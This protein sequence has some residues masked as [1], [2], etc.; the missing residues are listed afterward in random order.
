MRISR[1][2]DW[3]PEALLIVLIMVMPL[4]ALE[5]LAVRIVG[6]PPIN[7]QS[8]AAGADALGGPFAMRALAV[9]GALILLPAMRRF[10]N[11]PNAVI[12]SRRVTR[13]EQ[14]V[15]FAVALVFGLA[16]L[17]LGYGWWDP[18][19]FLGMG[20]YFP[21]SMAL[22]AGLGLCPY[23][24]GRILPSQPRL[25]GN[26]PRRVRGGLAP[27]ILMAFGYGLISCLWHCCSFFAPKMYFFFFVIKGVQLW[28][29]CAFFYGWGL[30]M[31]LQVCRKP[32]QA[33]VAVSLLFGFC[34]PWHTFG[35][36]LTFAAFGLVLCGI[37][38]KTGSYWSC[39]ALLYFAYLFHAGL[40]WHGPRITLFAILPAA[41]LAL[42]LS[43]YALI[44]APD[45]R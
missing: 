13:S 18:A 23:A 42:I 11:Q 31:L 19:A 25:L 4:G 34:Y 43:A 45:R 1:A 12:P 5:T 33:C 37:M 6:E 14:A 36:A 7:G 41:L 24:L 44:R 17:Y 39:W 26:Q 2:A 38:L 10:L 35:F 30:T 20:R 40:P 16:N 32:W 3:A 9:L 27:L 29:T 28:A 15:F 22:L 8:W 21:H